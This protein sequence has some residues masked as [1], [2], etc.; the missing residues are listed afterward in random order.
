METALEDADSL[1]LGAASLAGGRLAVTIAGRA[2]G[3]PVTFLLGG[4]AQQRA[5]QWRATRS[6]RAGE[7][8]GAADLQHRRAWVAI[9][10]GRSIADLLSLPAEVAVSPGQDGD[11]VVDGAVPAATADSIALDGGWIG[12]CLARAVARGGTVRPEDLR[13]APLVR[14]G[15]RLRA[16]WRRPGLAVEAAGVARKDGWLG[17]RIPLRVDGARKDCEGV[18]TGQ[19]EVRIMTDGDPR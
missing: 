11:S 16:M 7:I 8:L 19:G 13:P 18:V 3:K 10:G 14:G 6:L 15:E 4:E 17:S 12:A 1:R 2:R 9:L 5:D